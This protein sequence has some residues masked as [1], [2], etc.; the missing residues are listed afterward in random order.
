MGSPKKNQTLS[1]ARARAVREV[2]VT[3][4]DIAGDRLSAKGYGQEKPV[5]GNDTPAGREMNR[6]VEAVIT[7]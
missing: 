7:K 6:R 4:F 5:T 3:K 1:E 2:L